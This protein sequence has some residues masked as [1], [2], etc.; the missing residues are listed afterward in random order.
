VL[1][2]EVKCLFSTAPEVRKE[3][4]ANGGHRGDRT[5][6]RTRSWYD[7]MRSV[8]STRLLGARVCDRTLV[9]TDQRV[10]S[11]LLYAEEKSARLAR[12]VPHGTGAFGHASRGAERSGVMIGRAARPVTRDRMRSVVEGAY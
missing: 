4:E 9:W 2:G 10:R 11:V 3:T 6:H 12:P 5:L 1:F 8:S 7:R